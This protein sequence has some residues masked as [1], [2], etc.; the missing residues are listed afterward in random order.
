MKPYRSLALEAKIEKDEPALKKCRLNH[1]N[2]STG[3]VQR[4]LGRKRQS[5][6]KPSHAKRHR[7]KAFEF[8]KAIHSQLRQSKV[9]G[10]G[11]KEFCLTAEYKKATPSH[12]WARL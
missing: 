1:F 10:T 11:W 4:L 12:L 2:Q 6:E 7:T 5:I 8:G 9:A 3:F